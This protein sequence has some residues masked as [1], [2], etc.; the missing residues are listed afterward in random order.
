MQ[1]LFVSEA[2]ARI[3]GQSDIYVKTGSQ[4]TLTCLMSQGPH[5]LGTVAWFRGSQPVI[6]SPHSEND[7]N[8]EP[9]ITVETEWSEALTSR[10]FHRSLIHNF[11]L[12]RITI[13]MNKSTAGIYFKTTA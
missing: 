5:D 3:S 2:R 8:S 9:R 7:I 4:L 6:T 1:M 13:L 11:K 10:Y 12:L